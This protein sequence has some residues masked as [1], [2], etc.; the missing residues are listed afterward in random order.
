MSLKLKCMLQEDNQTFHSVTLHNFLNDP[1]RRFW[2]YLSYTEE[3]IEEI[4]VNAIA[5]THPVR[6]VNNFNACFQLVFT[7]A[8]AHGFTTAKH[9]L[10]SIG[11]EFRIKLQTLCQS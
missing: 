7:T 10:M 1:P 9:S 2:R 6:I 5:I 11:E 4:P 8:A 3:Q